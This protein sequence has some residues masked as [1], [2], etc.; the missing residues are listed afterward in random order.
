MNNLTD[1]FIIDS[2]TKQQIMNRV[3]EETAFYA[4]E[5]LPQGLK[6]GLLIAVLYYVL[7]TGIYVLWKHF[8]RKERLVWKNWV[9]RFLKSSVF[10]CLLVAYVYVVVGISILCR[11]PG[12]RQDV[13]LTLFSSFRANLQDRIYVVENL[14]MF[15]P[16][17]MLLPSVWK[18]LYRFPWCVMIGMVC[19]IAIEVVQYRLA[20]GYTQIDDVLNNTIGTLIGYWLVLALHVCVSLWHKWWRRKCKKSRKIN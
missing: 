19:S 5:Y 18:A 6:Y 7:C 8:I 20:R 4:V 13:N 17:G 9:F 16:F 1:F 15:V 11:D 3:W 2:Q 12:S 14:L 10:L